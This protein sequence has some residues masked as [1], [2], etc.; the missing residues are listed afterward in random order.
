MASRPVLRVVDDDRPPATEPIRV[1]G[2]Q[3]KTCYRRFPNLADRLGGSP[4]LSR[5]LAEAN[6]GVAPEGY[7]AVILYYTFFSAFLFAG[8]AG[9]LCFLFF[10]LLPL[11]LLTGPLVVFLVL[12]YYPAAMSRT[13]AEAI[14]NELPALATY[15]AMAGSAGISAY[16]VL[17]GLA[18]KPSPL[19]A[20]KGEGADVV[21]TSVWFTKDPL[22]AMEQMSTRHP[23]AQYR[24]WLSGLIYVTR[25][26]GALAK[27]L[28]EAADRA[29]EQLEQRWASFAE[30]AVDM[31]NM[32][33]M[34]Y[35]F[36]PLLV[37]VMMTIF[38]SN[39]PNFA[40]LLLYIFVVSPL[41]TVGMLLMVERVL[42]RTPETT[43]VFYVRVIP[44][45]VIATVVGAALL[46]A[47][48]KSYVALAVGLIVFSAPACV[49]FEVANREELSVERYLPEFLAD[50]TESKRIGQEL[51][52]AIPRISEFGRYSQPLNRIIKILAVNIE[53]GAPIPRATQLAMARLR[54]WFG[55]VA[56]FL[57]QEAF[58]TGG[59][60]VI[61]FERITKF[62]RNYIET[63]NRIRRSLRTHV[64][65]YYVTA[66]IVIA[67]VVLVLRFALLP[68][69]ALF[70]QVAG[71]MI[72][73][74]VPSPEQVEYLVA[75]T[76]TGV[77]INIFELGLLAGKVSEGSIISGFKHC[78]AATAI[79]LGAF[80]VAGIA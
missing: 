74:V 41:T 33:M 5:R 20:S 27:H 25:T 64:A 36:V 29:I 80:V 54:G 52:R 72:P 63:R 79:T 50:V 75:L 17:E 15:A 44:W 51:E 61:M 58:L 16:Q 66:L 6:M 69:S 38:T 10:S 22:L 24:A 48:F 65:M 39:V 8:G 2:R 78:A 55:R 32:V 45:L 49:A 62:A 59:G 68:Q 12:F 1:L 47:G 7:A 77:V 31:G 13:R 56:F 43:G 53:T 9:L 67:A 4:L 46:F 57:L 76:M 40:L 35:S 71:G 30:R 34:A 19:S 26:G 14:E 23:S 42:P 21:K 73:M 18:S 3:V 70:G 60:T 28:E 37:F 11:F